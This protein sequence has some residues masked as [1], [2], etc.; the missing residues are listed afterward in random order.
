[1]AGA[2]NDGGNL[3]VV[4]SG[5]ARRNHATVCHTELSSFIECGRRVSVGIALF[6]AVLRAPRPVALLG[7]HSCD[8]DQEPDEAAQGEERDAS[9][10][11]VDK[12]QHVEAQT[13]QT[14]DAEDTMNSSVDSHLENRNLPRGD[15]AGT[16]RFIRSQEYIAVKKGQ[17]RDFTCK[18][19]QLNGRISSAQWCLS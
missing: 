17:Q 4:I 5:R 3:L 19:S 11:P 14:R 16:E 7:G 2:P 15:N 13:D 10:A 18:G 6:A 9:R 8:D 12:A 1:M